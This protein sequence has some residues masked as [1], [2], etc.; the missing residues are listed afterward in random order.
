[1]VLA[2]LTVLVP[3]LLYVGTV[4]N[5]YS[6]SGEKVK[7]ANA[8]KEEAK[9]PEPPPKPPGDEER[10]VEIK[11]PPR[12]VPPVEKLVLNVMPDVPNVRDNLASWAQAAYDLAHSLQLEHLSFWVA[13][14]LLGLTALSW[15]GH[16]NQRA[17]LQKT[18]E[19]PA[20][21]VADPTADTVAM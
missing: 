6:S 8:P 2:A 7:H 9:Q 15:L 17:R 1:W 5:D 4:V 11:K 10:P 12:P 16:R 3:A 14:A 21:P 18:I 20:P 13:L 19:V